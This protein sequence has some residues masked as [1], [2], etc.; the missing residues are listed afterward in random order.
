M[1]QGTG[2]SA[3]AASGGEREQVEARTRRWLEQSYLAALERIGSAH[4]PVWEADGRPLRLTSFHFQEVQRKLK[5]FRWLERLSFASFLDVGSGF[6][7]Y[8]K[9]VRRRYGAA[10]YFSDFAHSVN[11]PYG[12]AASEKLDRAVTLNV[13]RLPFADRSFDVVLASEVLE[14]LVRPIEAIAELLRVTRKCLIMTSLEALSPSRWARLRSHFQVDVRREHVERN[15][16]L[17]SELE[18][19]FGP[20]WRHENLFYD[21][22]LPASS[23]AASAA[24]QTAYARIGDRETLVAALCRAV[25]ESSHRP[26][27]MGILLVKPTPGTE[28]AAPRPGADAELARWLAE[29][30]AEFERF[31]IGVAERLRAGGEELPAR[32]RPIDAQL[33]ALLCCPDCRLPLAAA[34]P[35]VHCR[36]CDV[37]FPVEY[38]VPI[39]YPRARS[40]ENAAEEALQRLCGNDPRRRRV[41]ARVMA[42]LRRNERPA[43]ALRRLLWKAMG[44]QPGSTDEQR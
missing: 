30:T 27:A 21:P 19:V 20:H 14:H 32:D 34:G 18:A 11:F 37:T 29:Q 9:L 26:G 13:A 6:D 38:G 28:I 44:N 22:D 41:V 16:F 12:G 39:L 36:A 43:G 10:G 5:I 7:V 33:L 4:E 40:E 23:V 25:A 8:P 3:A 35:G 42:K 17:L 24:Q 15:F 1:V 2:A 31:T